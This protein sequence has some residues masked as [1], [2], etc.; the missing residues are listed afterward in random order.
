MSEKAITAAVT[1]ILAILA[2]AG[3]AVLLSKSANTSN[4][5]TSSSS[6]F[7]KALCTALSP[8]GVKCSGLIESVTSGI[9]YP[10]L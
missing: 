1:V 4:V 10:G 3:L 6:G 2:L 9:T 5:L 8:L 7:A